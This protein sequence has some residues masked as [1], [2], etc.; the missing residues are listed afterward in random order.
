MAAAD[1]GIREWSSTCNH[2]GRE[3]TATWPVEDSAPAAPWLG[4]RHACRKA[5]NSIPLLNNDGVSLLGGLHTAE[6]GTEEPASPHF[7]TTSVRTAQRQSHSS[8]MGRSSRTGRSLDGGVI[9]H[10]DIRGV[11]TGDHVGGNGASDA[12]ML[13]YRRRLQS[14]LPLSIS[15]L[16]SHF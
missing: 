4:L 15:L 10:G 7:S 8:T 14:D 12:V 11:R 2:D 5:R 1:S 3:R 13:I 9:A 6:M 16:R